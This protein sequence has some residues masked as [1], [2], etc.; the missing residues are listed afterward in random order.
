M[1][2]ISEE[3][4]VLIDDSAVVEMLLDIMKSPYDKMIVSI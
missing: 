2:F 1:D 3:V 4:L